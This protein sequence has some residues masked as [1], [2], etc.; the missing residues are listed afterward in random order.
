MLGGE[1]LKHSLQLLFK[2]HFSITNN[3]KVIDDQKTLFHKPLTT[4]SEYFFGI[5]GDPIQYGLQL[6]EQPEVTRSHIRRIKCVVQ[7]LEALI[8][9]ESHGIFAKMGTS[10]VLMQKPSILN[11][12][13]PF[14]LEMS[15]KLGQNLDV[16]D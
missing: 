4:C 11:L 8:V 6:R 10:I 5:K 16:V 15:Q 7:D 2:Q 12:V 14:Y 13:G 3:N 1:Y 9:H